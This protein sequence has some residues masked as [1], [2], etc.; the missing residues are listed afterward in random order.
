MIITQKDVMYFE[1]NDTIYCS[2]ECFKKATGEIPLE[3]NFVTV[4][5][6]I[7]RTAYYTCDE[8]GRMIDI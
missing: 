5:D 2:V 1:A 7:D 6:D 4:D 8:C 3:E